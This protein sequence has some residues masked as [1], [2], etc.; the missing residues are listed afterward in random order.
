MF[1][2][3]SRIYSHI[4]F[5]FDNFRFY[6][7]CCT[8]SNFISQFRSS[9]SRCNMIEFLFIFSQGIVINLIVSQTSLIKR[10][11]H[12][13][14]FIFEFPS[15]ENNYLIIWTGLLKNQLMRKK[16]KSKWKINNARIITWI[17]NSVE[18]DIALSLKSCGS[19]NTI[20]AYLH[21]TYYQTNQ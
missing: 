7:I 15:R 8:S 16:K 2:F 5:R 18:K 20:L 19:G 1:L 14:N 10:I 13:G 9:I 3:A 6:N 11:I 21:R 17:L 12:F 4:L